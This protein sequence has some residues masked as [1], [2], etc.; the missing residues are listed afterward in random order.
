MEPTKSIKCICPEVSNLSNG[1]KYTLL[2][3]HQVSY[4]LVLFVVTIVTLV[5]LGLKKIPEK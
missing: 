4:Y 1:D 3:S 5:T 2:Q